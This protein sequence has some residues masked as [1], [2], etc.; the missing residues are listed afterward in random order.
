MPYDVIICIVQQSDLVTL[1]CWRRTS[2][3]IFALV[4][5]LLRER[6][7][8]SVRTFIP[9]V[10]RFDALMRKTGAVISGSVALQYFLDEERWYPGD[11]DIYVSDDMYD[12]FVNDAVADDQLS[13]RHMPRRARWS[14]VDGEEV[15]LDEPDFA[16]NEEDEDGIQDE[17]NGDGIDDVEFGEDTDSDGVPSGEGVQGIKAVWRFTTPTSRF[18]DVVRSPLNT[19]ITP[20]QSFWSTLVCNFISPDGCGCGYPAVTMRRV[21]VVKSGYMSERDIDAA[22]KYAARGF[23]LVQDDWMTLPSD[24][25]T[26]EPRYFGDHDAMVVSFRKTA[27]SELPEL[28]V[29][30]ADGRWKI[31]SVPF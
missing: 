16:G 8:A 3:T 6:Y 19:P 24:P 30:Y 31:P 10:P 2:Q 21:G 9:N 27:D 18:I 17:E 13:F 20:L 12:T 14:S 29:Q 26:W 15:D 23:G 5:K 28:P 11:M 7:E 1:L 22:Q 25:A 4:A